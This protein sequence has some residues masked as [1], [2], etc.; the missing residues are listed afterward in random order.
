MKQARFFHSLHAPHFHFERTFV[1]SFRISVLCV[2]CVSVVIEERVVNET[3]RSRLI[4]RQGVR[5]HG[6][7]PCLWL[8]LIRFF[9]TQTRLYV[10]L[11]FC[12]L[13]HF[14]DPGWFSGLHC[15]VF[16]ECGWNRKIAAFQFLNVCPRYPFQKKTS[17]FLSPP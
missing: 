12:H 14:C 17:L 6:H 3:P 16:P 15:Y 8:I 1:P 2:L 11:A 10:L 7:L 13:Y 9:I 4:K 5:P